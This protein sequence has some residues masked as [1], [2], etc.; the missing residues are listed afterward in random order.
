MEVIGQLD[1]LAYMVSGE[2]VFL[3]GRD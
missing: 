1:G 2:I 3:S